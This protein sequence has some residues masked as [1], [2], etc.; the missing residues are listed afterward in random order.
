MEAIEKLYYN[1]ERLEENY[2]DFD[3]KR[4]QSKRATKAIKHLAMIHHGV[5]IDEVVMDVLD[6]VND[7]EAACERQGFIYG[8][9]YAMKLMG[10]SKEVL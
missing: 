10:Q 4:E 9:S 7:S 8:F 1:I 6:K 2:V 3:F 5:D